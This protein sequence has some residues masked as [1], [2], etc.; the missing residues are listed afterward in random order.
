MKAADLLE[1]PSKPW[2][3]ALRD[4]NRGET[5]INDWWSQ[6]QVDIMPFALRTLAGCAVEALKTDNVVVEHG[7][8]HTGVKNRPIS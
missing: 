7:E 5:P 8:D 4:T 6:E 2:A 3:A 1:S